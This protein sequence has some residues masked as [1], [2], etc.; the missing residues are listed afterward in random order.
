MWYELGSSVIHNACMF[1]NVQILV[2]LSQLIRFNIPHRRLVWLVLMLP[3]QQHRRLCHVLTLTNH[4][5]SMMASQ[6]PLLVHYHQRCWTSVI[7]VRLMSMQLTLLSWNFSHRYNLT[8]RNLVS[9]VCCLFFSFI[10]TIVLMFIVWSEESDDLSLFISTYYWHA[11]SFTGVAIC[12]QN[13]QFCMTFGQQV[14]TWSLKKC[15][16]SFM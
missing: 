14:A 3:C 10:C 16:N 8:V 12:I 5:N 13:L 7:I 11:Y 4:Q 6:L 1:F 15:H 2:Y 9:T